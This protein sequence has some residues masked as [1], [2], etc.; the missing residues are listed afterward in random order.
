[1]SHTLNSLPVE[2]KT[3]LS[4]DVSDSIP[5]QEVSLVH[6]CCWVNT[7]QGFSLSIRYS[8]NEAFIEQGGC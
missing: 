4:S 6:S 3:C 2:N 5:S 8:D 1:M 7:Y